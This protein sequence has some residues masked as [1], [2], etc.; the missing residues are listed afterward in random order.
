VIVND[1]IRPLRPRKPDAYYLK[2]AKRSS[3]FVTIL[4]VCLIPVFSGFESIYKAFSHFT[5]IILPP[6]VVVTICGMMWK[7]FHAKA[8]FWSLIAGS[9]AMLVSIIYPQVITPL[10]HG[11][12]AEG[13]YSYIRSFYGIVATSIAVIIFMTVWW[14]EKQSP[15]KTRGLVTGSLDKCAELY[16]GGTP[17]YEGVGEKVK[18]RWKVNESISVVRLPQKSIDKLKLREGDIIYISDARWWLGGLRSVHAKVGRT[19]SESGRVELPKAIQDE[20]QFKSDVL[21]QVEKII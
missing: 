1:I 7:R 20:A 16:K 2:F 15:N 3:I 17:N 4:G 5:S 13:G 21:V 11:I 9:A 6:L 10:A 19:V 8:A 18:H 14:N 12:S